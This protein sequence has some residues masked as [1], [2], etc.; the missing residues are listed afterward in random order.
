[1]HVRA[2]PFVS[3][4]ETDMRLAP[5]WPARFPPTVLATPAA[6]HTSGGPAAPATGPATTSADAVSAAPRAHEA[7]FLWVCMVC[8]LPGVWVTSPTFLHA[9]GPGNRPLVSRSATFRRG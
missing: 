5:K 6:C 3:Q 7:T 1:M 4:E 8:S 2:A 9:A